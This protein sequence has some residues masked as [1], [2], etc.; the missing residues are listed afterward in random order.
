MIL[1]RRK[2]LRVPR[3]VW[4]RKCKGLKTIK[5]VYSVMENCQSH[6]K[7]LRARIIPYTLKTK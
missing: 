2:R 1:L 3:N 4:K 5:S 6:N 7:G